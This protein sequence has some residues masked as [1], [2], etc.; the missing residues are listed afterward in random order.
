M[1]KITLD[2]L[3]QGILN[4]RTNFRRT[5]LPEGA[6]LVDHKQYGALHLYLSNQHP[7]IDISYSDWR[8][9]VTR[10][11]GLPQLYG[12]SASLKEV[13]LKGVRFER[14]DLRGTDFME[15]AL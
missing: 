13:N 4:G 1:R 9:L 14:A 12:I 10:D 15:H 2:E 3:V 5:K 11:F 7:G 6:R 8:G